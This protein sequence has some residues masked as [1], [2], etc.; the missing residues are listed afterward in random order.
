METL[1]I[2]CLLASTWSG[3]AHDAQHTAVS[4]YASQPLQSIAWQTSVDLAPQ[5]SGNDLLIHYGSPLVTAANTVIVPVKTGA[6]NGF[7]I[8]GLNGKT[9][10]AKWTQATDYVLPPHNWVPSYG[11]TLT[12]TNRLYFA[13]AGGT[14]YYIDGPDSSGATT[15]GQLAFYGL[16]N[17][18]ASAASKAAFNS[19]V[20]INTPL[21]SDNAGNIYFGFQVTGANPSNLQSGIGRI[22]ASGV[23]SWISIAAATG[24]T[25]VTNVVTN[26]AP[27]L[28]NDGN[29]VYVVTNNANFSFGYLVALDSATLQRIGSGVQVRLK[30][31]NGNDALLP[32]DGTA[33]PTVGPNGD[34]FIGV[35]EN[36]FPYNHDRGWLLH[37]SGNLS[38]SYAP[39]A[40]GWD[41]T[42]SVVPATMVPS[43][44]GPSTYLLMTKYN[45]YAGVGGDGVNKLAIVDP[46]TN[47]IDPISGKT[48]MKEVLTIAG[49][50]PDAEYISSKPNA[51]REWCINTAAVDPNTGSVL[52]NSE[53][54]KLYRWNL[55]TNTFTEV[56]VLTQGIG[57]AYTPTVIG[58]DGTV[59]AIN[60]ATLFAVRKSAPAPTAWYRLNDV[61]GAIAVDT[62]GDGNSATYVNNPALNQLGAI[63]NDTAV[64]FNG[65]NQYVSLP[66]VPFGNYGNGSS[67]N[68]SFEVWFNAIPGTSG[69]I[70]SQTAN[71]ATPG[72]GAPAGSVPVIH[73]GNDGKLRSTLFWHNDFNA[74][75]V[76]PGNTTYNDGKWHHVA[77]TYANGTE[78]L[79]IDGAV[80]GQQTVGQFAYAAQYNYFLGTGY[81]AS[82]SNGNGGWDYFK[83][84]L[85]EAI[86]YPRGLTATEIAQHFAAAAPAPEIKLLIG[87]TDIIDGQTVNYGSAGQGTPITKTFTVLN[88]GTA[89][90]SLTALNPASMPAGF[91]IVTNLGSTVL[92]PGQTTSFSI[93]LNAAAVGSYSGTIQLLNND[94]NEN[95]FDLTL[96]GTV[97]NEPVILTRSV[98]NVSG[99]VL[100]TLLNTGTWND[101]ESGPVTL[102]ASLGS[103][104]KNANGTWAWSYVPSA[105]LMGQQVTI[106]A[107]D[108]TNISSVSF[109]IDALVAVIN[110]QAYYQGSGFD[111]NDGV[112]AALD[113]SKVLLRSASTTQDSEFTNVINYSRG[114]N[115]VVLDVAGLVST[116]L[117]ASD[118]VFRVAPEFASGTVAPST[119][120]VAP[121]PTLISVSAGT[122]TTAA[123]VKLVWTD[124]AIQNT[125]LQI[126]VNANA[127]TGLVNREVYYLG[128]ALGDVDGSAPYRVST[129]DGG[130]VRA[131][132]GNTIVPVNDVRDVDKDRRI[133]TIDV[134]F[135]RSRVGNTVLLDNITVPASGSSAEGEDTQDVS[136]AIP[137]D[138]YFAEL[139]KRRARANKS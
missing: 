94:S 49:V 52:A 48:V 2:R 77:V 95:P 86:I 126:I 123:R 88:D 28:S 59:Y 107:N 136:E 60:N 90:L 127:N 6:T 98:A 35:L 42:A 109:T 56:I 106:S 131:A 13:G 17:Y 67:Y 75:L 89:S 83:G 64:G 92:S 111:T 125:W 81:T 24:D 66:S 12:P 8:K 1:E 10:V 135:L 110:R 78:S 18:N 43:Y 16:S 73:L 82:W 139:G 72:G 15:S 112:S 113:T 121:A 63:A 53:D 37:F 102:T 105:R 138:E 71:G 21:T 85:D 51:V 74:R 50:T 96:V 104:V 19:S 137:T 25:S 100:S 40:F 76:S 70:F 4:P 38:S 65:V 84:A 87:A 30:D 69:V 80:V 130:L 122:V 114:I 119:W 20:F 108:G 41:D 133:T 120:A 115:G 68:L 132:V 54:G 5:Y 118:F 45:N 22:S 61:S 39:G 134:G 117:T 29:T 27:A 7:Q 33:S 31:P 93:R 62:S 57:E 91:T 101:P 23:G 14:I 36:P 99:N 34:V 124:N 46:S 32:N 79:Y 129:T 55:T 128:H 11:P 26:A 9:G 44:T 3:Y 103:I 97:V 116:T 47:M 58:V